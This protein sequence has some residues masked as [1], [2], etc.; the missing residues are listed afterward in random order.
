MQLPALAIAIPLLPY[1]PAVQFSLRRLDVWD[2]RRKSLIQ[3]SIVPEKNLE[4]APTSFWLLPVL[5]Q[6]L[7]AGASTPGRETCAGTK[8]SVNKT[9]LGARLVAVTVHHPYPYPYPYLVVEFYDP[10]F[11]WLRAGG[12][13]GIDA[14]LGYSNAPAFVHAEPNRA[15]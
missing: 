3:S 15:A 14:S 2:R 10:A 11:D 12:C 13:Q 5:C 4:M 6:G 7:A 9:V 1:T 8:P